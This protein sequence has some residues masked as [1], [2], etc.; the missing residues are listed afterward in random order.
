MIDA[1]FINPW[2]ISTSNVLKIQAGIQALPGKAALRTLGEPLGHDI[3]GVI[4][5]VAPNFNGCVVISFPESTYLKVISGMLG[6][7]YVEMN[8]ELIDGAAEITNMIFGQSKII[9]NEK[10][11]GIN[12][13]L[14]KVKSGRCHETGSKAK[15]PPVV[16]PFTSS[17]G[18]FYI[19]I[20]R[21]E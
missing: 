7:D 10:G 5:V 20:C 3:T 6:E 21:T 19:E 4:A 9:L 2:I 17:A 11:H 15:H 18:E 8:Q 12:M 14:P 1:N 16:I 13:A